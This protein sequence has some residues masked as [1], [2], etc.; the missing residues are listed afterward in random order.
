MII[1]TKPPFE[2][3]GFLPIQF[4]FSIVPLRVA[5]VQ[6]SVHFY[7]LSNQAIPAV[8]IAIL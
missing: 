5:G 7:T 2:N 4:G 3:G 6:E 1:S 8:M